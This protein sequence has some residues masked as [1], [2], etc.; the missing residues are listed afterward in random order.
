MVW[1]GLK[2]FFSQHIGLRLQA[3]YAPT[4][5]FSEAGGVWCNWWG[6]CWVV[7]ND[8]FLNQFDTSAGVIF[9]F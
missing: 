6:V 5:L 4:Y 9:R 1:A 2:Y 7:S 3:R 8:K